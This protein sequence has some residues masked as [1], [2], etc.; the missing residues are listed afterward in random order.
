MSQTEDN[1]TDLTSSNPETYNSSMI[2]L[3]SWE[4]NPLGP[5]GTLH[6]EF[7]SG[8]QYIYMK[9]PEGLVQELNH[10]ANN[11]EEYGQS[12]GQFF[13]NNIRNEYERRGKDYVRL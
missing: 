1:L 6:V 4:N 12:V 7:Q 2:A 11:P 3:F 5:N 13:L 9:V 8:E 10:R